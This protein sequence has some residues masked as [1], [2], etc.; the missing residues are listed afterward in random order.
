[1][2][3]IA[4]SLVIKSDFVSKHNLV[5]MWFPCVHYGNYVGG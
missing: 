1:M 4:A 2:Q 5:L 3:A